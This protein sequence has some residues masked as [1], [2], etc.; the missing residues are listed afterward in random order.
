LQV[1]VVV[2]QQQAFQLLVVLALAIKAVQLV[3]TDSKQEL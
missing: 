3:I 2:E 1:A